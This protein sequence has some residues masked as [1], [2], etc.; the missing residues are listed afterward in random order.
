MFKKSL[1]AIGSLTCILGFMPT[2]SALDEAGQR[3]VKM[4][5]NGGPTSIRNA[6]ES[7]FNTANND[8]EVLDAAAETLAQNF[9]KNPG[10]ETHADANAW[11]CK[12]LGNSGN[13]RYKAL[14][15]EVTE[16]AQGKKLRKHC[17]NAADNLPKGVAPYAVGSFNLA[18]YKEGAPANAQAA[19][20]PAAQGAAP[21]AAGKGFSVV[22]EGMSKEEVESLIGMPTATRAHITGKQFKPFNFRGKDVHRIVALYKGIGSIVYSNSSAYSATYTVLEVIND[23]SESGYP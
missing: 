14:L 11:L 18:Q 19:A 23:S 15:T 8:Q 22:K 20:K 4:F 10:S 5:A 17:N 9:R 16:Q 1:A 7:I 6:A 12:A 3:Y 2:A 13:G 21:S